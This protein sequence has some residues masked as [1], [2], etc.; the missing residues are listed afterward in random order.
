LVIVRVGTDRS[1]VWEGKEGRVSQ[2][3]S[4][5][6]GGREEEVN[7]MGSGL[8]KFG[9]WRQG[10]WQQLASNSKTQNESGQAPGKGTGTKGEK[11]KEK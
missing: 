4:K 1:H 10:T 7:R 5:R 9:A 11:A 6:C 2:W 3:M 8:G